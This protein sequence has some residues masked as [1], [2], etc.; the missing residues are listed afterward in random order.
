MTRR[1]YEP[2]MVGIDDLRDLLGGGRQRA[3]AD[4]PEPL[5][6]G[7]DEPETTPAGGDTASAG[8]PPPRLLRRVFHRPAAAARWLAAAVWADIDVWLLLAG[9]LLFLAVAVAGRH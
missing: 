2:P 1:D 4:L 9:S 3:D 8:V 5:D 6:L 7:L